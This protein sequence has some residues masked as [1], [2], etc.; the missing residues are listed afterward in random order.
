[1]KALHI[2]RFSEWKQAK[3]KEIERPTIVEDE[4]LIKVH[5][6]SVND[7]DIAMMIGKPYV[8][9]LPGLGK[10]KFN[11]SGC[12]VAGVVESIGPKV[13]NVKVGERVLVDLSNQKWGG[14]AEYAVS[15]ASEV[16]KLNEGMSFCEAAAL[17][18]AGVLAL[19]ALKEV[20]PL[21]VGDSLLI[22][23]AGG[24]AGH[25]I[26]KLAKKKGLHVTVVDSKEKSSFLHQA[27]AYETIDYTELTYQKSGKKYDRI[28]DLKRRG[29]LH[30]IS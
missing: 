24:G 21:N 7:F 25:I 28:I 29:D 22:N 27:G 1:M 15:K 12:D 14:Y 23:G 4:V 17:P 3:L 10:P 26:I 20:E 16:S 30:V 9:R 19:Q 11:V 5:A 8:L 18:Q 6:S 2:D 13:S